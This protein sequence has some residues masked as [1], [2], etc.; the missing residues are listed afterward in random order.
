[1]IS[2]RAAPT[3]G[4]AACS[5]FRNGRRMVAG[6]KWPSSGQ[7]AGEGVPR[8]RFDF[9][10]LFAIA[11]S[12]ARSL[13]RAERLIRLGETI[14]IVL[15]GS[16]KWLPKQ[17]GPLVALTRSGSAPHWEPNPFHSSSGRIWPAA[18]CCCSRWIGCIASGQNKGAKTSISRF[19]SPPPASPN[20]HLLSAE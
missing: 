1:M 5:P 7:R 13:A 12:P 19:F 8:P 3:G 2:V 20:D 10:S 6:N 18:T 14:A 4:W 15:L 11:S 9:V 17:A 16:R